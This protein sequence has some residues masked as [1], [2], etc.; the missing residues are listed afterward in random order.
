MADIGSRGRG[1]GRDRAR[2]RGDAASLGAAP[3]VEGIPG[4][5]LR[6]RLK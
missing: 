2:S 4:L 5:F 3:R 6:G 1:S